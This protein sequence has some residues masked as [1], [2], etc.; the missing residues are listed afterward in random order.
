MDWITRYNRSVVSPEEAV[1]IV[2]PGA[3]VMLDPSVTN[4][5]PNALAARGG[6]LSDVRIMFQGPFR[7]TGLA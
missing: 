7:G 3:R 5:I 1:E 4:D 2:K 6:E